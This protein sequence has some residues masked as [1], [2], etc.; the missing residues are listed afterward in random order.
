M[1]RWCAHPQ[2]RN[3]EPLSSWLHRMALANG[4]SNHTLVTHLLGGR[5]FWPRDVDRRASPHL[6]KCLSTAL[7][8]NEARLCRATLLRYEGSLFP[9][10][11]FNGWLPWVLPVGVYH[12]IQRH[13]GQLFCPK[14]LRENK[15]IKLSGRLAFE[16]AC[17]RHK[18]R[19]NDACPKC[20]APVTFA[21]V[22]GSARGKWPCPSCGH[23]LGVHVLH[24]PLSKRAYALQRRFH[25]ALRDGATRI[26][27]ENIDAKR[28][29]KGARIILRGLYSNQRLAGL[30]DAYSARAYRH[31]WHGAMPPKKPFEHWRLDERI[32][33]LAALERYL[34][35]WPAQFIADGAD[36]HV[37][38]CRFDSRHYLDEPTWLAAAL[39]HLEHRRG[40]HLTLQRAQPHR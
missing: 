31:A 28:F 21:R 29:F 7:G 26:G 33:A 39:D 20:D 3:D 8:V 4:V 15:T 5:A 32:L 37:Y 14:C 12:R 19:L 24:Q 18:C 11:T 25:R 36:A 22:S 34:E 23:N 17:T 2:L 10:L 30:T 13:H 16:V 35:A 9:Q 6:L 1:L 27:M 38:R 40:S